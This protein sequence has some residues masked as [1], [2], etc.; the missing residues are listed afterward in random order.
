MEPGEARVKS[1]G[2][3]DKKVFQVQKE[4]SWEK[5]NFDEVQLGIKVSTSENSGANMLKRMKIV[6]PMQQQKVEA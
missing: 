1:K 3:K 5:Q 4:K 6:N 2:A